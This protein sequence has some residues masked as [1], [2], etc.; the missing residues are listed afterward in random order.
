MWCSHKRRKDIVI[1][2]GSPECQKS[3]EM[4]WSVSVAAVCY[5]SVARLS[6]CLAVIMTFPGSGIQSLQGKGEQQSLRRTGRGNIFSSHSIAPCSWL[7]EGKVMLS[8]A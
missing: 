2:D 4:E 7:A 3:G 8:C 6:Y 5:H 1:E